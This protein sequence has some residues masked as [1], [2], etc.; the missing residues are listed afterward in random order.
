M[1]I[2]LTKGKRKWFW[3]LVGRNGETMLTSQGYFSKWSAKRS[4]LKLA[5]VNRYRIVEG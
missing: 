3:K 5:N 2:E 1:H 4:A